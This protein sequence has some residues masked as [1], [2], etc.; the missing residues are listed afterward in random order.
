M[1]TFLDDLRYAVRQLRKSPGFAVTAILTLALGIGATTAIFTLVYDVLLKPLPYSRPEQLVV[2]EEQ[3]A[4]F[5]DLYPTLPMN[6]N[7]LTFWQRHSQSFQSM[8]VMEENSLP[9]GVG[10]H[11]SQI[12]VLTATP[13]IFSVLD[14]AP[15][16]GRA[17]SAQE[18][19]PGH[20]HVAVLMDSFWRN[21]FQRDPAILGKIITLNG[22][23][24]TVVG[25]M[26]P[27][28]HL[29]HLRMWSNVDTN[30]P[31]PVE[32]LLP[33]AFSK[34][35]LQQVMG[36]FNYFGLARLKPGVSVSQAN[37]EINALQH[38][39]M[40]SL[41]GDEKATLSAS[42]TP[43]QTSLVGNNQ[44]PLLILLAAVAGLLLVGCVNIT[45]LLLARAVGK[46]QQMAVAA[47]LGASRSE[48]LRLAMRETTVLATVGGALGILLATMLMPVMQRYLP[49]ALDFRGSLH[50]DWAGAG[51]ALLLSVLATLVAGAAP[52]W[53]IAR[54][55]PQE[56]LHSESRLASESRSSKRIRR[57]LVA[58]EVAVSVALVL[59]TGLLTTSLLRLLH[60]DRG[61]EA[62]RIA[63]AMV[64]LPDKS[65][66][67]SKTRA[68]FY[69]QVLDR[70]SQ[71]P[72]VESAAAVSELPLSGDR[73]L[74]MLRVPGDTRPFMQEPSEHFRWVSPGYFETIRLP[75]VAGRLLSPSD[76][77]KHY[78][79]ISELTARAL[80]PGRNP[81]GV[82]F[83]R[84][85]R[86]ESPFTVIGVVGNARTVSL[87][88]PD[89][90]M[91]YMPYW[92]RSDTTAGLLVRTR[93]DPATMAD[94]IRR[95][96][97]S[98]DPEVPVPVVRMLGGVVADSV[99]NR[100][101]EM[102]LLLLFA[103]SALLLA[104]L[105]VYGVVTYS[106]I[107]RQRE[108]G[109]R[110][111]LGAQRQNIYRLVLHDGL[112]P[113]L[114][115]AV[116]GVAVAFASA[117]VVGSLLFQVSPYNSAI[118]TTAVCVLVAMG[119]AAC[120]LP[121]R[122]AAAVDPMQALRRE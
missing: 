39:I 43:F 104:G 5:H 35:Q 101:F 117:R 95:A 9:L 102:Q 32:A 119:A 93:Q 98:V 54:T 82:Q 58:V 77:G 34:E 11:P 27:S 61:F 22:F 2:M 60:V 116:A 70:L 28:F 99:A 36:D 76:E 96:I 112:V 75:L 69:K 20:E 68:L 7:H 1:Q 3:V 50:L 80:W 86:N 122:R 85:G 59:M 114:A 10:G 16:L 38:T 115:G 37:A 56:V 74:D 87:A 88:T 64:D 120:L 51:C 46:R 45:N 78:A 41:A 105:G 91:V 31:Q 8:A 90:M 53:M 57:M 118:A 106:V 4:E 26:P 18:A 55:P 48:M 42:L 97:W 30:H 73:W 23:P 108:I 71:L 13:G 21:Q 49:P 19:Q 67:D 44:K 25:V 107:Q 6:A 66:S 65:Y 79:V 15:L 84:G 63:T 103:V 92:Y 111:A 83:N 62:A 52:A 94:T 110:L 72:G 14:S 81:I 29:P 121:A 100:R 89:P 40:G 12:G 17:F 109:L 47:A 24:Y 113:V 33:M